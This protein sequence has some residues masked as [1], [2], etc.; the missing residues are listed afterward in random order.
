MVRLIIPAGAEH[1]F[2]TGVTSVQVEGPLE[3]VRESAVLNGNLVDSGEYLLLGSTWE[4]QL[5]YLRE[6]LAVSLPLALVFT[7]VI[8]FTWLRKLV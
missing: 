8:A 2:S 6:E 7:M 5:P 4:K 1:P 3:V